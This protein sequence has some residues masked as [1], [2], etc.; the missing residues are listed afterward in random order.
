M[1]R[2]IA[3]GK[4]KKGGVG[5]HIGKAAT[6]ALAGAAWGSI[7]GLP[8]IIGGAIIG[9]TVGLL[10]AGKAKQ[11]RILEEKLEGTGIEVKGKYNRSKLKKI[12]KALE[13]GEISDRMRRKLEKRG[14]TALLDKIDDTKIKRAE[15]KKKLLEVEGALGN[16]K[17]KLNIAKNRFGTANFTV[18]VANFNGRGL[19]GLFGRK[20]SIIGGAINIGTKIKE[21]GSTTIKAIAERGSTIIKAVKEKGL[22]GAWEAIKEKKE[23]KKETQAQAA[24]KSFDININGSLK[25]TGDNGQSVDIISELRKNPQ[26]L[27]SL[28]DMIAKEISYLEKGTTVV[29]K[30]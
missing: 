18:G 21:K 29:Q 3:N 1:D 2:A 12:N 15:K 30:G 9:G 10:K 22:S 24:P 13:T 20:Q 5:H 8:G 17:K 11:E 25:L 26:V 7:L 4:M 16:K 27:R 28:A 6:G 14:D 19:N 23:S